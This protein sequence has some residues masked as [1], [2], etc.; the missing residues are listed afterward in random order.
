MSS[1]S[2]EHS[3]SVTLLPSR[4]QDNQAMSKQIKIETPKRIKKNVTIYLI[5]SSINSVPLNINCYLQTNTPRCSVIKLPSRVY[6]G[7]ILAD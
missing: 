7:C 4:T 6:K 1:D 2:D 5:H 3:R